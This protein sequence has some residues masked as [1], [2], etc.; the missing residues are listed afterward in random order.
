MR[1]F[2]LIIIFLP[3]LIACEKPHAEPEK[4]DPIYEDLGKEQAKVSAAIKATEKELEGFEKELKQVVPQTGQVKYAQK[5]VHDTKKKIEKL[6]QI[7][8]YWKLRV[9]S[10]KRWA[11]EKYLAA[12][13]EKKPWPQKEEWD[14]YVM[15]RK[16]EAAP[17]NWDIRERLEQSKLGLSLK[18]EKPLEEPGSQK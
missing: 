6:K 15:Q 17:R 4:L 18:G 7:E 13:K 12:Y 5:R 1:H 14:E 3:I 10:R 8:E 9:E 2:L 11:R 16:L